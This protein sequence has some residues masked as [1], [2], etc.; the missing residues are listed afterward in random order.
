[1]SP[2]PTDDRTLEQGIAQAQGRLD[3]EVHRI[4]EIG[5]GADGAVGDPD[6]RRAID[7]TL[8]DRQF[9]EILLSTLPP[10]PSRWLAWDLPHRV[11]RR[12]RIPLT[13]IKP[14][15]VSAAADEPDGP[16]VPGP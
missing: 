1:M 2:T 13:V 8:A 16:R 6:P 12:T 7:T 14:S 5:A 9:D 11:R 15:L 3:T 4:R 10:G